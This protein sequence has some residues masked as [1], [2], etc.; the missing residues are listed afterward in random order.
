MLYLQEF[1]RRLPDCVFESENYEDLVATSNIVDQD[2]RARQI[3]GYELSFREKNNVTDIL[4]T[5]RPYKDC[6]ASHVYLYTEDSLCCCSHQLHVS[7][8]LMQAAS[9]FAPK[10]SSFLSSHSPSATSLS[11]SFLPPAVRPFQPAPVH[12]LEYKLQLSFPALQPSPSLGQRLPVFDSG[13]K[14]LALD[15]GVKVFCVLQRLQDSPRLT[16]LAS[17][18]ALENG[19]IFPRL[20][21]AMIIFSWFEFYGSQ[22][23][24]LMLFPFF[25]D[26][27]WNQ[28]L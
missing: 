25:Q 9:F 18:P 5:R 12:R 20:V 10:H 15:N 8:H 16:S 26:F 1:L 19:H 21:I 22:C 27:E 28:P 4:N 2:E 23:D 7:Q 14:L 11:V 13:Y 3:K 6:D 24:C 17:F